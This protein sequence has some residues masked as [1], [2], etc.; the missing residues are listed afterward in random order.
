MKCFLVGALCLTACNSAEAPAP[1]ERPEAVAAIVEPP[2]PERVAAWVF[3]M[4]GKPYVLGPLGEDASPDT[5]PL[6]RY[7][8]FDCA[9]LN[10]T[11]MA[12]A[13]ANDAGDTRRAMALANY[14]DGIVSYENRLHFTT[15]RLDVSPYNRDITIEVGGDVVETSV[16]VLNR[17]R[18][19]SRWIPIDWERKRIVAWIP[20]RY[21]YEFPEWFK[22][23]RIPQAMGVAFVQK[24]FHPDGLDVVHESLLFEGRTLLHGSSRIGRVVTVDWTEFLRER[25]PAYDGFVLFEYR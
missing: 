16:V 1:I 7:D 2:V 20:T 11:A 13:H 3:S 22:N 19:G 6:I 18:D 12:V 15:D 8:V 4:V 10:L 17:K 24:R 9:T 21:A 14:R 23:G 5:D 25:G